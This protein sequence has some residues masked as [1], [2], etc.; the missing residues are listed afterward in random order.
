MIENSN[1]KILEK[2]IY[3]CSKYE[4]LKKKYINFWIDEWKD[5]L[6]VFIDKLNQIKI[7]SSICPHFGG[8]IIYN[9]KDNSLSCKW[10]NWK[11]CT[12]TGKCQ[13]H[14][15]IGSLNNYDF[16]IKPGKL[17]N[18]ITKLENDK[19]YAVLLDED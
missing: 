13:T 1:N 12:Q 15:I 17:K 6:I 3:L 2:K 5:E 18:Y 11:F 16:T 7:F 14:K 19:I 8:K 10:H 4:I 9:E